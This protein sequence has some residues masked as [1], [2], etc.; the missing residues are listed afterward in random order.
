[1]VQ[2]YLGVAAANLISRQETA[3][4]AFKGSEQHRDDAA[5]AVTEASVTLTADEAAENNALAQLIADVATLEHA[6]ACATVTIAAPTPRSGPTAST[7]RLDGSNGRRP[8]GADDDHHDD[9][10]AD[11]NDDDKALPLGPS[12]PT[13]TTTNTVPPTTTS[14]TRRPTTTTT[15]PRR[16]GG[17][18]DRTSGGG[19]RRHGVAGLHRHLRSPATA[20]VLRIGHRPE[21]PRGDAEASAAPPVPG[22]SAG[23][24]Q[25]PEAAMMEPL[26]W[27]PA[28]DPSLGASP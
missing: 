14:T 25:K 16:S 19:A 27:L 3:G 1:M 21:V 6:G 15:A 8:P 4:D 11:D 23:G 12:T 2:Q 17:A 24:R 18:L 9:G 7:R 22:P 10:A 28:I 5:K 26:R 13:T 20:N